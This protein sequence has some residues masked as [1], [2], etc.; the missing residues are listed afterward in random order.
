M[1][2]KLFRLALT[3][4]LIICISV[5]FKNIPTAKP[6]QLIGT[7]KVIDGSTL[8]IDG[9]TYR[10][11]GLQG[12][13]SRQKCKK[14]SLPW[15]C[16]AAAKKFVT[17]KIDGLILRCGLLEANTIQ[18]FLKGRDLS[19]IIVKA[20]WAVSTIKN[21]TYKQAERHAQKNGLGLWPKTK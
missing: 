17:Q 6:K 20:G 10:L 3:L 4:S 11:A 5:C 13:T 19:V 9:K 16:G 15:L 7:F 12:P 18:C 1:H 2:R 8:A 21:D 14:G